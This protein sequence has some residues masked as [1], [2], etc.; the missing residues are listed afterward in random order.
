MT[1]TLIRP[2]H[3][4]P[5]NPGPNG[6]DEPPPD[7]PSGAHVMTQTPNPQ[8]DPDSIDPDPDD[9]TGGGPEGLPDD[10]D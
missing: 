10:P 5:A 4:E 3:D 1:E 2:E 7:N 9:E 8:D 6:P